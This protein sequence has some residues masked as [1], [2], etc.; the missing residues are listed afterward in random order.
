MLKFIKRALLLLLVP[1]QIFAL[2]NT[3]SHSGESSIDLLADPRFKLFIDNFTEHYKKIDHLPLPEQR[4]SD[5]EYVLKQIKCDEVV[6]RT[7]NV[8]ILGDDNN[9]I[10]LRIYVP[11]E[12]NNLPV[13]VYFHGGG[14]TF[15]GI[16][17]ADAVCRRLANHLECI[18]VSVEYRLAPEFPFPK[19]LEDCYAATKW[20]ADHI[21]LFGGDKEN[22]IVS[23]ESAGGNLAAAVA[24]LARDKRGLKL[25]AQVLIYPAI[26]SIIRDDVYDQCPDHYFMTKDVMKYFWSMYIQN[27][28]DEKNRYHL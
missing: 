11:S 26:S 17:E 20:V 22:I 1:Y 19:P 14:W 12:S 9:K 15:G 27:P 21:Q 2:E 25:S 28:E 16:D 7:E 3:M 4:K 13:M 5:A 23:G 6:Q 10:P 8:E 18:I 24:L